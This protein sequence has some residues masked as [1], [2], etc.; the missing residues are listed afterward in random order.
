MELLKIDEHFLVTDYVSNGSFASL[1]E[2]IEYK[3]E[4]DYAILVRITDFVK[5][6][7]D[8]YVYINEEEYNFLEKSKIFPGDLIVSNVG[9]P[10]LSFILP[11]LGIQTS[12]APNS[13]VV[14]PK[15]NRVSNE[16][17]N[18]YLK[19]TEGQNL[20]D[21]ICTK[22]TLKKF[23][24]TSFRNLSI[25]FPSYTDQIRIAHLLEKIESLIAERKKSI[26]LLEELVKAAFY[27]LFGDPV[28]NEKGWRLGSFKDIAIVDRNSISPDEFSNDDYYLGL[29]D[30]QK[31]TG[32]IVKTSQENA[33]ELKSS[34][35]KFSSDHI[36][37]AKLRP[38]LNK[39]ALPDRNGICSTDI[40]PILP[41]T[42]KANKYFVCYLMR[43]KY[44]VTEMNNKS[45]GANLP[46]VGVSAIENFKA[47]QPSLDLQNQFATVAQKIEAL[48]T[49]QQ[50]QLQV[51]EEL[52]AS[53]TQK[54][55]TGGLDL[56]KIP[57][58]DALLPKEAPVKTDEAKDFKKAAAKDVLSIA[59]KIKDYYND[60]DNLKNASSKFEKAFAKWDATLKAFNLEGFLPKDLQILVSDIE[61]I[62][63]SLK[64]LQVS[65][66]PK[67]EKLVWDEISFERVAAFIRS[68]FIGH[69]FNTEMLLHYL[70]E[71]LGIQVHYFTSAEQKKN[72]QYEQA[73][74]F[75]SF[76]SGALTGQN[77]FM[78]LE[79]VFYNAE[80]ENIPA[81]SFTPNDLETL[82]G[83]SKKER[84]GIYFRIK[85]EVTPG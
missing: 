68:N 48:K 47:Y 23:N 20:I 62:R 56:S 1:K 80:T 16:Y 18:Y 33:E 46:R 29:E 41:I 50:A 36:L 53:L 78:Q 32:N 52:Y 7:N 49:E 10:G 11:D 25:A 5:N 40:F 12:L 76:V 82:A 17:L 65:E 54:A 28:R 26:E 64:Q 3:Y 35:F 59:L 34:K 58:D 85:D 9:Q 84:S 66:L 27:Q 73:D 83:K 4:P 72:P 81:I 63:A 24:K 79:Q 57:V 77:T 6:W 8:K 39:V 2:N 37:Y 67:S 14:R 75:L 15:S 19:T 42:S 30:I 45:S 55:F 74:D 21:S 71:N 22:T 38:Y 43:N 61:E 44:F 31:E 60:L 51:L 69:Y 13:I 70:E